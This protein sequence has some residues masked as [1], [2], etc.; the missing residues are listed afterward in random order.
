MSHF[1]MAKMVAPAMGVTTTMNTWL[2]YK[3]EHVRAIDRAK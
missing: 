1:G 2:P 3:H